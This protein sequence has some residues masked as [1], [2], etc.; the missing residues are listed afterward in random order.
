MALTTAQR[1]RL[2]IQDQPL[3]KRVTLV[4]DGTASAFDLVHRNVTDGSAYVPAAGGWSATG[5]TFVNSGV[6]GFAGAISAQSAVQVTYVH[7]TF[8]N[9]EIDQFL[10]DGGSIVGAAIE[11]VQALMF[12]GL[13]RQKWAAP[14][15]TEVDDT[16]AMRLLNDLYKTLKSEE[17]DEA[18]VSGG[19]MTSW[20]ETQAEV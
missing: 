19:G 7:S 14:D 3:L 20:S 9:D 13:R 15:G 17:D 4:G 6:V 2:K 1:V 16:A 5:A 12:D 10:A 8:S 18:I 11:A